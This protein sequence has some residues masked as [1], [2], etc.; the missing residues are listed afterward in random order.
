MSFSEG[1]GDPLLAPLA[2]KTATFLLEGRGANIMFGRTLMSGIAKTEHQCAV[3]DLDAFYSS[4]ADLIFEGIAGTRASLTLNVPAPGS[5]IESE[6]SSLF[7]AQEKV[8][9]IDSLNTLYHLVSM[10]D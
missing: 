8:V 2:G 6:F 9:V 3:F 7:R 10:E 4:N 5:D 1:E